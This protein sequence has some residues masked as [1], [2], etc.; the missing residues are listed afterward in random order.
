MKPKENSFDT[1]TVCFVP[2]C[3]KRAS[4][5]AVYS[6]GEKKIKKALRDFVHN[7]QAAGSCPA[8]PR[9]ARATQVLRPQP[10]LLL[11]CISGPLSPRGEQGSVLLSCPTH[12][13]QIQL[14]HHGGTAGAC[15]S[16]VLGQDPAPQQH[17]RGQQAEVSLCL[18][19]DHAEDG[20]PVFGKGLENRRLQDQRR[21]GEQSRNLAVPLM[22][23]LVWM[24][25][26]LQMV[27]GSGSPARARLSRTQT[28][29]SLPRKRRGRSDVGRMWDTLQEQAPAQGSSDMKWQ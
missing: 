15:S 26:F 12:W 2:G 27:G 4:V 16:Q 9:R 25:M 13:V 19:Q 18:Q 1:N 6:R 21:R 5:W 11:P 8:S 7:R 20:Q 28:F 3:C 23:P 29:P 24:K 17:G 22:E 10:S 14:W